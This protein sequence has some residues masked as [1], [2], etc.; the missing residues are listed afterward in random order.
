MTTC[1]VNEY[2]NYLFGFVNKVQ[3][4]PGAPWITLLDD[5]SFSYYICTSQYRFQTFYSL[6]W[7][8]K[9]WRS[10]LFSLIGWSCLINVILIFSIFGRFQSCLYKFDH[11]YMWLHP[12]SPLEQIFCGEKTV[13]NFSMRGGFSPEGCLWVDWWLEFN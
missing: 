13:I 6:I 4:N 1:V 12:I 8:F 2:W 3:L 7:A 9:S 11:S 5:V 10:Y